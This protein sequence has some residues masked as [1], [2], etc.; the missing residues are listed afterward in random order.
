[1]VKDSLKHT[2]FL[3]LYGLVLD[4]FLE[5]MESGME[6]EREGRKDIK[7]T[8]KKENMSLEESLFSNG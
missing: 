5:G 6:G 2:S 8:E 1:M 7:E 3:I 4:Q